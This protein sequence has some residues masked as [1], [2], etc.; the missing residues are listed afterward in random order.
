MQDEKSKPRQKELNIPR[1]HDTAEIVTALDE[2]G[3]QLSQLEQNS[4]QLSNATSQFL[5]KIKDY[6]EREAQK[7]WWQL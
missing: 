2:R 1:N 5:Q 6:N 4:E 7:K 3:E